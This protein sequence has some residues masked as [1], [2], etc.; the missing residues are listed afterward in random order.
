MNVFA[1]L[2]MMLFVFSILA[3]N[4]FGELDRGGAL[5]EHT[6]Y[7]DFF[8]ALVTLVTAFTGSTIYDQLAATTRC[9]ILA[10]VERE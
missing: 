1:A 8:H 4:L 6:N 7:E 10:R 3:M 2:I 9:G 5:N